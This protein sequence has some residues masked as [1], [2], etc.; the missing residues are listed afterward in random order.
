MELLDFIHLVDKVVH[1][2]VDRVDPVTAEFIQTMSDTGEWGEAIE[3]LMAALT[4]DQIPVTPTERADLARLVNDLQRQTAPIDDLNVVSSTGQSDQT[5]PLG[6]EAETG[7]G[8]AQ[9]DPPGSPS[10]S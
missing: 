7:S 6:G 3:C 8:T 2:F 9:V 10:Q 4:Q 1:Q 5:V